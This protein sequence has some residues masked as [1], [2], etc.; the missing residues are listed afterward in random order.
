MFLQYL[1]SLFEDS[2]MVIEAVV[3]AL[4]GLVTEGAVTKA[5]EHVLLKLKEK[6]FDIP[7]P[8]TF[9]GVY[10]H[11]LIEFADGKPPAAIELFK[12]EFIHNAFRQAYEQNNANPLIAEIENII[13]WHEVGDSFQELEIDP[14]NFVGEFIKTFHSVVDRTRT[15]LQIREDIR[16]ESILSHQILNSEKMQHQTKLLEDIHASVT[17]NTEEDGAERVYKDRIEQARKFINAGQSIVGKETLKELEHELEGKEISQE[18]QYKLFTNIASAH[19]HL[20]EYEDA[21]SYL[22]AAFLHNKSEPKAIANA[23]LAALIRGNNQKAIDL[24]KDSLILDENQPTAIN[25]LLQASKREN[26]EISDEIRQKALSHTE[27]RRTLAIFSFEE[28]DFENAEKLHRENLSAPD[29]E[30][31]DSILLAQTIVASEQEKIAE[32]AHFVTLPKNLQERLAEAEQLLIVTKAKWEKDAN[33]KRFVNTLGLLIQVEGLQRKKDLVWKNCQRIF[34]EFPD[35]Y[36]ALFHCGLIEISRSNY[37]GAIEYFEKALAQPD[38]PRSGEIKVP[39]ATSYLQEKKFGKV[40]N[41]LEPETLSLPQR[42]NVEQLVLLSKAYLALNNRN[43]A[44]EIVALLESFG[45]EDSYVLEGLAQ[46]QIALNEFEQARVNLETAYKQADEFEKTYFSIILAEF[47][48][49]RGD[50]DK[51]ASLYEASFVPNKDIPVIGHYLI[52]LL[53]SGAYEKANSLARS[54]RKEDST[55]P[56]FAVVE[57]R[58]AEYIG[59]L[60]MREIYI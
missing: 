15:P 26:R 57:A 41:L 18:L 53:N 24:S 60:I 27:C 54:F 42:E 31:Q 29:T 28:K 48:Y 40:I 16:S 43:R 12:H 34:A 58:I 56:V 19:L 37:K 59:A 33:R 47:H 55:N 51:A 8:N 30:V 45:K 25:V 14:K 4:I 22:E 17:G 39:L 7:P 36:P 38:A 50:F 49:E 32:G 10:L 46:V 52:S 6:G 5:K 23:A 21:A 2:I 35:Y 3:S 20:D 9:D 44:S 11:A 13:D 1:M